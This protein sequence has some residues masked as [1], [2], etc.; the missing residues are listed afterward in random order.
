MKIKV[1]D[2]VRGRKEESIKPGDYCHRTYSTQIVLGLSSNI[3]QNKFSP[4]LKIIS[5]C[6]LA[7]ISLT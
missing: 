4:H 5:L 1:G 6:V 2:G 3:Q 7:E